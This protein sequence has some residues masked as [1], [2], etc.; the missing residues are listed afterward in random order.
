MKEQGIIYIDTSN[1]LTGILSRGTVEQQYVKQFNTVR[2]TE[3]VPA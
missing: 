1:T 2:S 3:R